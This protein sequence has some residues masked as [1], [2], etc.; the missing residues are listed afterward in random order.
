MFCCLFPRRTT[1]PCSHPAQ[2][3][4]SR[5]TG[6]TPWN[7]QSSTRA[8]PPRHIHI[9]VFFKSETQ[10]K[11]GGYRKKETDPSKRFTIHEPGEAGRRSTCVTC[12]PQR[13]PDGKRQD[14]TPLFILR[15]LHFFMRRGTQAILIRAARLATECT[16]PTEGG[17]T[18]GVLRQ[19]ESSRDLRVR[20]RDA[21]RFPH[22]SAP[23]GTSCTVRTIHTKQHPNQRAPGYWTTCTNRRRL[24]FAPLMFRVALTGSARYLPLGEPMQAGKGESHEPTN[25]PTLVCI[26][27]SLPGTYWSSFPCNRPPRDLVR[28]LSSPPVAFLSSRGEWHRVRPA[29]DP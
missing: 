10:R 21:T 26:F 29:C 22:P 24:R 27:E 17:R 18:A 1:S 8:A 6:Q 20:T 7:T 3:R 5:R 11:E 19:T 4:T 14:T 23:P 16:G 9:I 15:L 12:Q 13:G 25:Y 28:A 2:A